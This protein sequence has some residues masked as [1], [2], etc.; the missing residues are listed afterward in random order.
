MNHLDHQ[1]D[2]NPELVN[3]V[4]AVCAKLQ[5]PDLAKQLHGITKKG[6]T[7]AMIQVRAA[8]MRGLSELDLVDEACEIFEDD[9]LR[10]TRIGASNEKVLLS[11]ALRTNREK[12][13]K[14]LMAASNSTADTGKQVAMIRQC[15]QDNNMEGAKAIY[16]QLEQRGEANVLLS[17]ALL[18]AMVS[19]GELSQAEQWMAHAVENQL[20]D[21]VSYNTLLKAYINLGT[22]TGLNKALQVL[23]DMPKAVTYNEI[24]NALVEKKGKEASDLIE[25]LVSEMSRDGVEP[26]H[27][28]ASIMLKSLGRRSTDAEVRKAM[29]MVGKLDSG[30]D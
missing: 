20:T 17:N 28:T 6:I 29:E 10:G 4:I 1:S 19:C 5:D 2:W 8:W 3:A 30:M 14:T 7:G 12:L 13:S 9:I 18:D 16:K 26:N 27:V 15:A 11:L 25:S 21:V 22:Q 24:L 23:K